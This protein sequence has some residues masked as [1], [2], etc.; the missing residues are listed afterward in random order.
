VVC[1]FEAL[2]ISFSERVKVI[3]VD[4]GLLNS[5]WAD[6]SNNHFRVWDSS[7][8]YES[9]RP[10]DRIRDHCGYLY[11]SRL[12]LIEFLSADTRDPQ[13]WMLWNLDLLVRIVGGGH[14]ER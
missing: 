4:P 9:S 1:R 12:T 10:F 14:P 11:L 3:S 8:C 5:L 13:T 2:K 7:V 6:L